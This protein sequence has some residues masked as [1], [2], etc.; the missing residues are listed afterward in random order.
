MVARRSTVLL[1]W[2]LFS[3]PAHAETQW[4]RLPDDPQPNWIDVNSIVVDGARK[5][6][7][8]VT[9]AQATTSSDPN[10]LASNP[11]YHV[12]FAIDCKTHTYFMLSPSTGTWMGPT[13]LVKT[14]ANDRKMY[15]IVC[16]SS[17]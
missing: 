6:F 11:K 2:M 5:K 3:V 8:T 9:S 10:V 17:L 15:E 7:D 16:K 4:I 12:Q 13:D 1:F 14:F